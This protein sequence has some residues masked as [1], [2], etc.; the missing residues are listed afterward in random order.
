MAYVNFSHLTCHLIK[1]KVS[2]EECHREFRKAVAKFGDAESFM[3]TDERDNLWIKTD[4]V[5]LIVNDITR[6]PAIDAAIDKMCEICDQTVTI[7]EKLFVDYMINGPDEF[8]D[9]HPSVIKLT[10]PMASSNAIPPTS[11]DQKSPELT[12]PCAFDS[13]HPKNNFP[14]FDQW[15]NLTHMANH[16]I[17]ANVSPVTFRNYFLKYTMD[18]PT[19]EVAK[20]NANGHHS[21]TSKAFHEIVSQ[22][23]FGDKIRLIGEG[24]LLN[25]A[26]DNVTYFE[27]DC[28]PSDDA[29][30]YANHVMN[31]SPLTDELMT[32]GKY[33]EKKEPVQRAQIAVNFR[34]INDLRTMSTDDTQLFKSLYGRSIPHRD[35][36]KKEQ[37][38]STV[39]DVPKVVAFDPAKDDLVRMAGCDSKFAELVADKSGDST[40]PFKWTVESSIDK[41]LPPKQPTVDDVRHAMFVALGRNE[42]GPRINFTTVAV[43]LLHA[44]ASRENCRRGFIAFSHLYSE[45]QLVS[46]A[47]RGFTPAE[48]I[49]IT[50]SNGDY[51]LWA[52]AIIFIIDHCT[53]SME[54]V[55]LKAKIARGEL[56]SKHNDNANA[57]CSRDFANFVVTGISLKDKPAR[58]TLDA[59]M[60]LT[61]SV[62]ALRDRVHAVQSSV[63]AQFLANL[64]NNNLSY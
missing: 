50:D 53:P 33:E 20:T 42:F 17:D 10:K 1:A 29:R 2:V 3:K 39:L 57:I 48:P 27:C 59:A 37:F 30:Q 12:T 64:F 34:K 21:I 18:H 52:D 54:L 40:I 15:I 45:R 11:P 8:D 41:I 35:L 5:G 62:I 19:E 60:N 22:Y 46:E 38:T 43:G 49:L 56:P 47:T 26:S 13:T 51:W 16:L 4:V 24:V 55:S 6:N 32:L 25:G 31:G 61:R 63:G 14:Q 7:R 36:Y 44:N 9:V 58:D 23:P 28:L